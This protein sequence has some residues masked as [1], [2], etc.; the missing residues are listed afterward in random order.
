MAEA[1]DA[2]AT[3]L[4]TAMRTLSV[5]TAENRISDRLS[6]GGEG[7][8][9]ARA[10]ELRA[11]PKRVWVKEDRYAVLSQVIGMS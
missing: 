3:A 11:T 1:L 9:L 10:R 5:T 8:V 2:E 4:G 6:R 7:P